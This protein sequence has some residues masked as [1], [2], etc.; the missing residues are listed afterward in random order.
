[1]SKNRFMVSALDDSKYAVFDQLGNFKRWDDWG[2]TRFA[3][4][5]AAQHVAAFAAAQ[6]GQPVKV[7]EILDEITIRIPARH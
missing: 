4:K 2:G 7:V 3:S 6:I 5:A 1:M